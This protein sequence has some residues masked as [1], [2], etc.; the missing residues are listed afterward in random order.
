MTKEQDLLK[1]FKVP[2]E[3]FSYL[4]ATYKPVSP[5]EMD[6]R[7]AELIKK[8][9]ENVER[10]QSSEGF[11]NFLITMAHFH[12]YSWNNTMLIMLQKPDAT[13]VAGYNTWISLGRQV[14]YGE[15]GIAI[16][17]P[18]GPAGMTTWKRATDGETFYIKKTDKGWG[19]YDMGDNLTEE[20][21]IREDAVKKLREWGCIE[22]RHVLN[23]RHFKAVGVFDIS[24]TTGKPLPEFD[25]PTLTGEANQE[26]FD[27]V[28]LLAKEQSIIL[29]LESRPH[30]DP[31][32]KGS[33]TRPNQIWVRPEEAPAQQLKSLLHELS[34]YYSVSIFN[35][36]RADAE[37]IAESAAYIVGA[38]YGFDSGVRSFPY[39]ALWA[40]DYK[41]FHKNVAA[42]QDV[43]QKIIDTLEQ[44]AARLMPQTCDKPRINE[45]VITK[46]ELKYTLGEIKGMARD[47]GLSTTGTK[48][49]IIKRVI[50]SG[51]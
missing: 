34:H 41:V 32:I 28:I 38:F 14:K 8:V 20:F 2:E 17:A 21:R 51:R 31:G 50:Q 12:I 42:I 3:D 9:A 46:T 47:R 1:Y 10:I 15:K 27:R 40:Q 11:R 45:I 22:E 6:R 29:S 30:Q 19:I 49:D 36:P 5:E 4:P 18:R 43:A 24:Q 13:H 26:L 23:V 35:I 33:F 39:I 37:T 48:R 7:S 25:V 44:R 16:L